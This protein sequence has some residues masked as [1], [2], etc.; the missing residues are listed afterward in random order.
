MLSHPRLASDIQALAWGSLASFAMIA[1]LSAGW[2]QSAFGAR[3]VFAVGTATS[4][5]VALPAGLGWLQEQ[6]VPRRRNTC[7]GVSHIMSSPEKAAV[8]QS[9][10]VVCFFS[11]FLGLF[12]AF[13]DIGEHTRAVKSVV[14]LLCAP[15]MTLIVYLLLRRTDPTIARLAAFLY[16]RQAMCPTTRV[17]FYWYHS[18]AENGCGGVVTTPVGPTLGWIAPDATT[19]LEA[20][21]YNGS[22]SRPMW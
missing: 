18:T 4:I 1:G 2:L 15:T 21:W 17:L 7:D 8:F 16:L 13:F 10:M 22:P 6:R 14:V 9:S 12:G 5:A 3:G 19:A 11:V 20:Q